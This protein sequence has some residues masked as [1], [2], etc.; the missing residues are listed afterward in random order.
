MPIFSVMMIAGS[1]PV[2][3]YV[4]DADVNSP[5]NQAQIDDFAKE[6]GLGCFLKVFKGA[7][8]ENKDA[9]VLSRGKD[10]NNSAVDG[11]IDENILYINNTKNILPSKILQIRKRLTTPVTSAY[12]LGELEIMAGK[13]NGTNGRFG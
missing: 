2:H 9:I 5:F 12:A 7:A 6:G 10:F 8:V 11:V 3:L 13:S 4:G 1:R